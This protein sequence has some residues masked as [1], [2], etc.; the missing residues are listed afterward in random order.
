MNN[1]PIL[2][3][4]IIGCGSV[5]NFKG[6]PSLNVVK[7]SRLIAVMGRNPDLA[8]KFA[9][10]HG[11]K[12]HYHRIEDLLNDEE[13]NAVYVAT[14]VSSH[15]EYAI[16]AAKAGKHVLC[17][18][19][20][21]L[22]VDECTQMAKACLENNITL[23]IAYYRRFFPNIMKMKELIS[24]GAIG[25]IIRARVMTSSPFVSSENVRNNWRI[26][27]LIGGGGVLMDIGSHR[28]DLLLY[29]FGNAA[30]AKGIYR[31]ISLFHSV[32][33]S[34][35]FSINFASRIQASGYISWALPETYDSIEIFGT[36]GAIIID[37]INS[38]N[39][40]LKTE[41][42]EKEFHFPTLKYTHIG[43]VEDFVRHIQSGGPILCSGENG[44][45]TNELMA[46]I[47][48]NIQH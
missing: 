11:A 47:Y 37:P 19:P 12:K 5:A 15:R 30:L 32:E 21:A 34:I 10:R 48:G 41:G 39:L 36:K 23:M 9:R 24:E 44:A 27:P 13:V 26:D 18:K 6:G 42:A 25:K 17:E 28:I 14:P 46:Q 4:G 31:S 20:M 29:L 8:R 40:F 1:E 38:G 3:W 35:A 22:N 45:K 16:A 7:G 2:R 43:L 33:D